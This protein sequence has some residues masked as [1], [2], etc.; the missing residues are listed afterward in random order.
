MVNDCLSS[1]LEKA[2]N[3]KRRKR[4]RGN[5]QKYLFGW[6]CDREYTRRIKM[7]DVV[8]DASVLTQ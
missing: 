7:E 1:M 8:R 3:Y 2:M 5:C 6:P 4:G